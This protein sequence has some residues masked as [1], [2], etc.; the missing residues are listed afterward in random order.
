MYCVHIVCIECVCPDSLLGA[1]IPLLSVNAAPFPRFV[2]ARSRGRRS[3][4]EKPVILTSND[5][6]SY[7]LGDEI[8][9]GGWGAV[10][11][12][13]E[14]ASGMIYACKRTPLRGKRDDAAASIELEI[15]LLRRLNHKNI[16][17]YVD[18][19]RTR[20][21]LYIILEYMELGSLAD[22]V[23]RFGTFGE[24][25]L[26]V[27]MREVLLGLAY[28]H[29]QGVVHRDIKG[30]NILTTKG[31][32]VKLADFGVATRVKEG[33]S[34]STSVVGTPYWMAPEVIEMAG[35]SAACD[36]WSVGCTVVELL[37]EH[38]PYFDLQPMAALFR[39]VQDAHPPLP[40]A[41]GPAALPLSKNNGRK[42]VK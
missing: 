11:D 17:Q 5:G 21:H 39:I 41:V 27:Y 2:G 18:T 19:V 1:V 31:G 30:A 25:V 20:R 42:S 35:V 4:P 12:C 14:Q 23:R 6:R 36:V 8:G 9:K 38:P 3:L 40:D 22:K 7:R 15:D 32:H 34:K 28:L 26:H 29:E 37:T 16:V 33:A 10:F 24:S 13:C